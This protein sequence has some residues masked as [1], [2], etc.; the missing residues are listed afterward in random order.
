MSGVIVIGA[1][2]AA[3]MPLIGQ[4]P[5]DRIK[6][7][8]LPVGI[9]LPALA[10]ES[11]SVI[12]RQTL[13]IGGTIRVRERVRVT[14]AASDVATRLAVWRL[15]RSACRGQFGSLAGVTEISVLTDIAGPD[16]RN[17]EATIYTRTQD[18]MVSFLEAA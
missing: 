10:V 15:V 12:D 6:A 3:S 5:E 11:I 1:L 16:M 14:V 13:K 17:D 8:V 18:F 7:E 4:V 9:K 2:L